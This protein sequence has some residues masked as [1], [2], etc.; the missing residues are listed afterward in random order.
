[1]R[2]LKVTSYKLKHIVCHYVF[3]FYKSQTQQCLHPNLLIPSWLKKLLSTP[4]STIGGL[5]NV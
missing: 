1:M 2:E 4:L 3:Y 5:H